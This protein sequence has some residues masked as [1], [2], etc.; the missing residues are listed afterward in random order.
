M[1][2][3]LLAL[4]LLLVPASPLP[5]AGQPNVLFIAVDDL[6]FPTPRMSSPS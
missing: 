2:K 4:L 6:I 1:M 3:T 5:A